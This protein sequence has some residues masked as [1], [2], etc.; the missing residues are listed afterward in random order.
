M[1]EKQSSKKKFQLSK[2]VENFNDESVESDA[3]SDTITSKHVYSSKKESLESLKQHQAARKT[4]KATEEEI[5][6]EAK[7]NKKASYEVL[8]EQNQCLANELERCRHRLL[9]KDNQ[10]RE[11][12]E[13]SYSLREYIVRLEENLRSF[14]VSYDAREEEYDELKK[15]YDELKQGGAQRTFDLEGSV[16]EEETEAV[17]AFVAAYQ[18][19]IT[20]LNS[21]LKQ[22]QKIVRPLMPEKSLRRKSIFSSTLISPCKDLCDE[23]APT[24]EDVTHC[25][26]ASSQDLTKTIVYAQD[27]NVEKSK[28]EEMVE[29]DS[30]Q[31]EEND[32]DDEEEEEEEED[33][34]EDEIIEEEV[35]E[36][37]ADTQPTNCDK[38]LSTIME[39]T[40]ENDAMRTIV[41]SNAEKQVDESDEESEDDPSNSVHSKTFSK[42]AENTQILCESV[43]ADEKNTCSKFFRRKTK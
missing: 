24:F 40:M 33:D 13:E 16:G 37:V 22:F 1:S 31:E 30:N 29:E 18:D 10:L 11:A 25:K 17:K 27:T 28:D 35:V 23:S 32:N 15:K 42:S 34:D 38:R 20:G 5:E 39:M 36:M 9:L 4:N 8:F 43:V 14:K 2:Q 3:K 6:S 12:N 19:M 21:K 26:S 7:T 41:K